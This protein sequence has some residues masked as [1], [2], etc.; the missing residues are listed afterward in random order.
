MPY[1]FLIIAVITLYISSLYSYLLFHS[2]IEII[3]VVIIMTIFLLAWNA[4]F[5][6]ENHYLLFIGISFFS[7]GVFDLMHLFAYK[8][9]GIFLGYDSNLPTQLWVAFRYQ[10]SL[11]LL[12]APIFIR[13]RLH[14]GGAL[15]TLALMTAVVLLLIFTGLFPDCY[16]EGS[17]LTPFKLISEYLIILLFLASFALLIHNRCHFDEQVFTLLIFSVLCSI[18]A[19]LFFTQYFSVYSLTNLIG[20]LFLFCSSF[21]IYRA[22][23]VTGMT[24]PMALIFRN[25]EQSEERLRLIAETSID[26]I[27][28]LDLSGRIVFCSPAVQQYGFTPEEIIETDFKNFIAPEDLDLAHRIFQRVLQ[29]ESLQTVELRL[30]KADG[31]LYHAEINVSPIVTSH[32]IVGLQGI[33][34]DVDVRRENE[35]KL[36][37]LTV[38][39]Q[40]ANTALQFSRHEALRLMQDALEARATVERT[41]QD[42]QREMEGHKQAEE[43]I[44]AS[45]LEK[46][47]LLREIHH[48]VKNNLQV[49]SSLIS[50]QADNHD[51][52]R[53]NEIFGDIRDRVRTM[54]LVHEKLYQSGSLSRLN[55]ADYVASLLHYLLRSHGTLV[56]NIALH[57][58]V[59]PVELPIFT[60]VPCGL[61]INELV[62]NAIKHAF[63]NSSGGELTVSL[64]P[65][66]ETAHVCLRVRDNGS[67]LPAGFDWQRSRS[68]GLRLVHILTR[69]LHGTVEAVSDKGT[70][71][72]VVFPVKEENHE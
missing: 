4:R 40:T 57:L 6:L 53:L 36:H 46:E 26:L 14:V 54:A 15:S 24:K 69:Q 56:K 49:I 2:L 39:L 16:V 60:A 64:Q 58:D 7:S 43:Q 61:I 72:I 27:F 42:L 1:A 47:I 28:Q 48:R 12:I 55:V 63:D 17:G 71:F 9:F 52:R 10:F 11:T 19:E 25:L 18:V 29:G 67:G 21:F 44:K 62:G 50:L 33:S 70:E 32:G 45:L 3:N 66:P 37:A 59:A 51:D 35:K 65:V 31:S 8:G 41:N 30:K 22:I 20:H 68:L 34:R 13:W 5:L 38:E 23:V